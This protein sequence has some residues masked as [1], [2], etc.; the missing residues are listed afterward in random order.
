MKANSLP[1]R[2]DNPFITTCY[3]GHWVGACTTQDRIS[4]VR[5]FTLK[6]C[7]TARAMDHLQKGVLDAIER[8]VRQ[9][10]KAR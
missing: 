5:G 4:M 3:S 8:R 6:Q 7:Q 2:P 10:E 1:P 9:L